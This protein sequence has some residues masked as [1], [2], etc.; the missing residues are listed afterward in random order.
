MTDVRDNTTEH[1]YEIFDDGELAGFARY[2]RDD[3]QITF[4][5][6]ETDPEHSGRGLGTRLV[7]AALADAR[8]EG[9]AVLPQCPFV[10]RFIAEHMDDYLDLVPVAERGRFGLPTD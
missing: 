5:H 4:I 1:R 6:T 7:V 10:R 9:L 3:G 2:E 8:A